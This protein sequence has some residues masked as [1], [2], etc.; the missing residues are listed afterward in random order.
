MPSNMPTARPTATGA[1]SAPR[2]AIRPLSTELHGDRQRE[3][4]PGLRGSLPAVLRRHQGQIP[5]NGARGQYARA[6]AA[7]GCPRR[8]LLRQPR[9]L[10]AQCRLATMPTT[11][12]KS[13]DL[14]RRVRGHAELRQG[15]P[16]GGRGRSGLHDRHG[17]ELG[18]R[19]HG[20]LRPLVRQLRLA[21]ME[22][23]RHQLR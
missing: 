10:H 22:P 16:A 6:A 15:Q 1:R 3:R 18:H 9:V 11:A 21:A 7:Y 17:A 13:E 23:Q 5:G 8:A 19:G 4:R 2:P 12:E 14:C 20:L